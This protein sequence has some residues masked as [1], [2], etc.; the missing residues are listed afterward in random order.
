MKIAVIGRV[1]AN[2]QFRY[3]WEEL[4][5]RGYDVR[6]YSPVKFIYQGSESMELKD[7]GVLPLKC[8]KIFGKLFFYDII[9]KLAEFKPDIVYFLEEPVEINSVFIGIISKII[10][11]K[12]CF[13]TWENIWRKGVLRNIMNRISI[14][15]ANHIFAG[16]EDAKN[17]MIKRGAKKEKTTKLVH[18]GIDTQKFRIKNNNEIRKITKDK[19]IIGYAGRIVEEKRN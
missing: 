13:I 9:F 12:Y 8:G 6:M 19:I 1:L 11:A 2:S 10:G 16:N 7:E 4:K 18:T 15:L 17:F 3:T 14:S 5:K